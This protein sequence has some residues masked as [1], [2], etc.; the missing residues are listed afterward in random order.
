[1]GDPRE[2][3]R[4]EHRFPLDLRESVSGIDVIGDARRRIIPALRVLRRQ[5]EALAD[6]FPSDRKEEELSLK[7]QFLKTAREKLVTPIW[8]SLDALDFN[9][10]GDESTRGMVVVNKE[11]F[12]AGNVLGGAQD[13]SLSHSVVL[14][15]DRILSPSA[16][17]EIKDSLLIGSRVLFGDDTNNSAFSPEQLMLITDIMDDVRNGSTGRIL[18]LLR[19]L[20]QHTDGYDRELFFPDRESSEPYRKEFGNLAHVARMVDARYI[21][22]LDESETTGLTVDNSVILGR[23]VLTRVLGGTILNSVIAGNDVLSDAHVAVRNCFVLSDQGMQY[24]RSAEYGDPDLA[25][26][27]VDAARDLPEFPLLAMVS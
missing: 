26:A 18:D 15:Y 1:M 11:I 14:G 5:H 6:Y 4:D 24:V 9:N 16:G 21:P 23:S 2:T 12:D 19:E 13:V 20:D 8:G 27:A 7:K 22:L 17:A 25:K 3:R 10:L